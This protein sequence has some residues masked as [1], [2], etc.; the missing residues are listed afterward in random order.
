VQTAYGASIGIPAVNGDPTHNFFNTPGTA[1]VSAAYSAVETL[2]AGG[3]IET[4][5][6][7]ACTTGTLTSGG[8]T[9]PAAGAPAAT[10]PVLILTGLMLIGMVWFLRLRAA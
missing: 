2:G 10:M 5:A 9:T 3:A 4:L 8:T 7:Q 6:C 1:G